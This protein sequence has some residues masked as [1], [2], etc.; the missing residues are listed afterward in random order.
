MSSFR[1]TK[2]QDAGS[3]GGHSPPLGATN[4]TAALE[5]ELPINPS[6]ESKYRFLHGLC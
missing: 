1:V 5:M 4:P 3:E 6:L 2:L